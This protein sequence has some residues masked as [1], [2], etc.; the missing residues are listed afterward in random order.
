MKIARKRALPFVLLAVFLAAAGPAWGAP[1]PKTVR[2][3]PPLLSPEEAE[4]AALAKAGGGTVVR[5]DYKKG[6]KEFPLYQAEV[7]DDRVRCE[8]LVDA[9]TGEIVR[10]TREPVSTSNLQPDS[11]E[12]SRSDAEK[13]ALDRSG[14][15]TVVCCELNRDQGG[16]LRYDVQIVNDGMRY[17]FKIDALRGEIYEIREE[18]V[19]RFRAPLTPDQ[20]ERA[21]R[22]E[23]GDAVL[24]RLNY[25]TGGRARY[26]ADFHRDGRRHRLDIDAMSGK[27]LRHEQN[28][29]PAAAESG[30]VGYTREAAEKT[31]L[32]NSDGGTVVHYRLNAKKNERPHHDIHVVSGDLKYDFRIDAETGEVYRI[33]RETVRNY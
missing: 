28:A 7:R 21:A 26:V 5:L 4:Q 27:I 18:R 22:A 14:G 33:K 9:V 8:I 32:E 15:G 16:E 19:R 13:T 25:E 2:E 31:A 1:A 29:P 6:G 23:A 17:D 30:T 24:V 20:A 12:F 10:Y 3:L 11:D